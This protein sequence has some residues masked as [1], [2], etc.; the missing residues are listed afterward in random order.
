MDSIKAIREQV[1][2]Y[3]GSRVYYRA[4]NGRR[5]ADARY[6]VIQEVY[7]NLFTLFVESQNTT[8]SFS[9]ADLLTHEVE[10]QVLPNDIDEN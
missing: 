2:Q 6:A 9:Y 3:K 1:S 10:L 8:V 4:S 7:P 5:K